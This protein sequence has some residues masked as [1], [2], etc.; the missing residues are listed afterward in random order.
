MYQTELLAMDDLIV[1]FLAET[2]ESLT[3][4]DK[5]LVLLEQNPNDDKLL[6]KIFRVMHTIKGTCGFLG[7]GRLEKV[8]HAGENILGKFRDKEIIVNTLAVTLVLETLD[9]I[10]IIVE[11][12][13]TTGAEPDGDDTSLKQRIADFISSGG[14]EPSS[15]HVT[16]PAIYWCGE[17][18]DKIAESLSEEFMQV[19]KK[20]DVTVVTALIP[21]TEKAAVITAI[22]TIAVAQSESAS[23]NQSIRVSVDLLEDLM[24]IVSELVLTR[25]QL[26]QILRGQQNSAFANALQRLNFNVS[27]LQEGVMKTRMQPIGNAW[28]KLPRIVRDLTNEPSRQSTN[29]PINKSASHQVHQSSNQIT[30]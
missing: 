22:P 9:T 16:A 8:A 24:T 19:H 30:K 18:E 5:D 25:N 28:Q 10:K 13:E 27:E 6:S 20:E 15:I 21:E 11:S 12:L 7:L 14:Q 2:N 23:G 4:L 1:E 3:E 29:Q 26:L 17:E